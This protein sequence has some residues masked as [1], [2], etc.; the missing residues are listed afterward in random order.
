MIEKSNGYLFHLHISYLIS[1]QF[2]NIFKIYP[3][4]SILSAIVLAYGDIISCQ[5]LLHFSYVVIS[6]SPAREW[7]FPVSDQLLFCLKFLVSSKPL[8]WYTQALHDMTSSLLPSHKL[9]CYQQLKILFH[10]LL[11]SIVG[12][13]ESDSIMAVLLKVMFSFW[14]LLRVF[15]VLFLNKPLC[16][17]VS[18]WYI[19]TLLGILWSSFE[20]WL[21][22]TL[23]ESAQPLLLQIFPLLI[24]LL[25]GA[26]SHSHSPCLFSK[27]NI[28]KWYKESKCPIED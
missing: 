1:Y 4:L 28:V 9:H 2:G 15:C 23:P 14:V 22:L 6:S 13:D 25:L 11:A 24:E 10:C 20:D 26:F 18:L 7:D 12:V 21:F 3:L 17:T 8:L 19:F 5:D 16:Y 27:W